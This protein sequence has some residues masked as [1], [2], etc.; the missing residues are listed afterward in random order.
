VTYATKD[1]LVVTG[2]RHIELID[3]RSGRVLRTSPTV[4]SQSVPR[5]QPGRPVVEVGEF[6]DV[7]LW[8]VETG[9]LRRLT[10]PHVPGSPINAVA[11]S[12]DGRRLAAA[13]YGDGLP[14]LVELDV[15]TGRI[16]A[17]TAPL[18]FAQGTGTDVVDVQFAPDGS[19]IGIAG[20]DVKDQRGLVDLIDART[21][22]KLQTIA[23]LPSFYGTT[24]AF[25]PDGRRVAYGFLDG[26]GGVS[27]VAGHVVTRFLG[28]RVQAFQVAFRPDGRVVAESSPDGQVRLWRATGLASIR[29]RVSTQAGT[30]DLYATDHGFATLAVT[31]GSVT[32][33]RWGP[34]GHP[35]GSA[36]DLGS[37]SATAFMAL[38]SDLRFALVQ[39]SDLRNRYRREPL[40][41][42]SVGQRRVL[43][44]V[45]LPSG[46][47][48]Y[49]GGPA[50]TADDSGVM[51]A[52]ASSARASNVYRFI[53]LR[54][55]TVHALF[56]DSCAPPASQYTA[57]SS[58]SGN[59]IALATYC[60]TARIYDRRTLRLLGRY[61]LGGNAQT[62]AMALSPNGRYLALGAV[63]GVIVVY[64]R[65]TG[66]RYTLSQNARAIY[67]L[68]FSHN[69]RY[70]ASGS[71]DHSLR[72]FSTDGFDQLHAYATGADAGVVSWATDDATLWTADQSGA[73]QAWVACPDCGDPR[74]LVSLAKSRVTRSL[75]AGERAEFGLG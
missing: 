37:A 60:G 54:T 64:D 61:A 71:G 35:S 30:F 43:H 58:A 7:A 25:S 22:R 57:A 36:F 27:T 56:S 67:A 33:Q 21:L 20:I 51:M 13:L 10:V 24:L 3:P 50:F 19:S 5:M 31:R 6:R 11:F 34:T 38:S 48:G 45:M 69:G 70:L 74:A 62:G 42:W 14:G 26:T 53:D 52:S 65:R 47:N 16:L 63:S 41:I 66:R 9:R 4:L 18:N 55:G 17:K 44:R 2:G 40:E 59:V 12:P 29:T 39:P 32:M 46:N 15:S 75:T 23:S 68:A 49:L 72:V 8:N 73:I 1:E 28:L